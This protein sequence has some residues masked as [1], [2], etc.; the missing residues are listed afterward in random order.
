M[1]AGVASPI[2]PAVQV[3]EAVEFAAMVAGLDMDAGQDVE[4]LGVEVEAVEVVQMATDLVVVELRS[5]RDA[6]PRLTL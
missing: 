3:V 2:A 1:A 5:G 6:E 4:G